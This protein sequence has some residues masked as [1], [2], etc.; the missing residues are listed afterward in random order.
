MHVIVCIFI[1][2]N[3]IF[4]IM[5]DRKFAHDAI[6]CRIN[7]KTGWKIDPQDY[8]NHDKIIAYHEL[9]GDY[10]EYC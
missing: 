8:F 6:L 10:S 5:S 3:L 4:R 1:C 9:H 2:N 7:E